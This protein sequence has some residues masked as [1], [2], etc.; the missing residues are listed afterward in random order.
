MTVALN[1]RAW[2]VGTATAVA[3]T[4]FHLRRPLLA[5]PP[6]EIAE[7]QVISQ[8]DEL[9]HGWPTL[10]RRANGQLLL[11][12]SGGRQ[13][14]VCPF[15][16]VQLMRSDDDGARWSWPRTVMD[17]PIDD[18]DAGVLETAKGTILITTFTSLA[19]EPILGRAER[20]GNWPTERL[21]RWRA[22]HHRV[23]AALRSDGVRA[24]WAVLVAE[25]LDVVAELPE[26][27]C[28]RTAGEAGAHDDDVVLSL[29]GGVH[30]LHIELVL[31]PAVF[32]RAGRGA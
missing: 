15:G 1:R 30:K 3:G 27:G 2:M 31:V 22:A 23:D 16:Y 20:D 7:I 5:A 25:A 4:A 11:V 6:V 14:H 8:Q 10:T 12:C 17:G 26:G 28:G 29:I 24:A 9:Y 13:S 18:R 32:D 19:Y 21:A